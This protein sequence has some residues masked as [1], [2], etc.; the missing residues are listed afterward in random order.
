MSRNKNDVITRLF[1]DQGVE[2]SAAEF[3]GLMTGYLCAKT[4]ST[5]GERIELYREWLDSDIK[6]QELQTLEELYRNTEESLGDFSDFEFRILLPDDDTMISRRSS[7]L[8]EWCAGFLSGF[9]SAGQFNQV[10]LGEDV[11]DAFA[12]FSKIASLAQEVSDEVSDSE[13]N[14]VDLMEICEYVRISVL[15]IFT[16]CGGAKPAH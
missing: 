6:G 10:D 12:D 5:A 7:A 15:V 2:T 3:H 8:S 4:N 11:T 16:E 9:G 14:E 13:E 1:D